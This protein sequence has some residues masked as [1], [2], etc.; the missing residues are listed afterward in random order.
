MAGMA[1][2]GGLAEQ[3][4]D[5]IPK[6]VRGTAWCGFAFD[7]GARMCQNIKCFGRGSRYGGDKPVRSSSEAET[8]LRGCLAL[9]RGG[10]SPEEASSPRVRHRLD[11]A[12]L[13]P[14]SEAEL[15]WLGLTVLVGR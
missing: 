11:S 7:L 3:R 12:V 2:P 4:Q 15:G 5:I 10:T 13:C 9:E 1:S 6:C 8:C 14:S